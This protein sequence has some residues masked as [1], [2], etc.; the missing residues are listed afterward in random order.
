M[1]KI[2]FSNNVKITYSF[3]PVLLSEVENVADLILE[4]DSVPPATSLTANVHQL[5][6]VRECV[7][8]F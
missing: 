5:R 1:P 8:P 6:C 7:L 2:T 3:Q 4:V